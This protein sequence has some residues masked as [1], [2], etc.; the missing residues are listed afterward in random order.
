[1]GVG[2]YKSP[3][4][5]IKIIGDEN[6]IYEVDFIDE[7]DDI[8]NLTDVIL[9]CIKELE[10]YFIGNLM[11]FTVPIKMVGTEFQK[12][13]WD[14]LCTIEYGKTASYKDIAV[15]VGNPKASRAVGGANNKNSIG[16]IVP[17][18]RVIGANKKLVGYAGGLDKKEWL[19]K[20]E[21]ETKING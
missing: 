13:V 5:W 10:E 21:Y 14:K 11:N 6:Y 20:H 7:K 2:Y 9:F 8:E 17:C 19:L 15:K 18:H 3:I 1:M 4:G 16:I 12:N